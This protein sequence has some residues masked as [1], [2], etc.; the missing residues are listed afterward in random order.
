MA[1]AYNNQEENYSSDENSYDENTGGYSFSVLIKELEEKFTCM[2]CSKVIREFAE[3]P[4]KKGHGACK[5]CLE[6]WEEQKHK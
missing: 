6:R 4:C 3:V 1:A 5:S 2:I